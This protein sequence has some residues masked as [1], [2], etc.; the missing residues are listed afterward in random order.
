NNN[1]S[2]KNAD[3]ARTYL[4]CY[5]GSMSTL[6]LQTLF[7][8]P[9]IKFN[10]TDL[11]SREVKQYI[12]DSCNFYH[13]KSGVWLTGT[14]NQLDK[15]IVSKYRAEFMQQVKEPDSLIQRDQAYTQLNKTN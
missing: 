4:S 9:E 6:M 1:N 5:D 3:A 11:M 8:P 13:Q 2:E 7:G 12:S 15:E 14:D 10:L